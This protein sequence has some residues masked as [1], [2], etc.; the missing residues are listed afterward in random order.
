MLKCSLWCCST[1]LSFRTKAFELLLF[2]AEKGV[3]WVTEQ[4]ARQPSRQSRG[5]HIKITI[6][7]CNFC[8]SFMSF[9]SCST[10]S[11][12]TWTARMWTHWATVWP[13]WSGWSLKVDCGPR[14]WSWRCSEG[15]WCCV[16]SRPRFVVFISN[17]KG[18]ATYL[19]TITSKDSSDI[20]YSI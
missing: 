6:R 5:K 2:S 13:N 1:H 4:T 14:R 9:R 20:T 7:T 12:A 11:P 15:I 10:W 17:V 19:D 8:L 16:T 3:R 18:T